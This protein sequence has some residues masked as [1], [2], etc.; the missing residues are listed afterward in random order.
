MSARMPELLSLLALAA[1][2]GCA[3]HGVLGGA[4]ER[5]DEDGAAILG[6]SLDL[7]RDHVVGVGDERGAFCSGVLVSRRVVLT[8]AHCIPPGAGPRGGIT[9]VHVGADLRPEAARP[10]IVIEAVAAVPHPGFDEETYSSDLAV[11]ELA[12][13]APVAPAPLLR[14]T[15]DDGPRYVGP[16]FAFVGHGIDEAGVLLVRRVVTFPIDAVGPADDA[17]LDTGSGPVDATQLYYRPG[18]DG[19]TCL[20]DSGGPAFLVRGGVERVAG[21]SSY[22]DAHCE[23]DGVDARTDLPAIA[24]FIQPEIDRIE[25]DDPC[26]AD[27]VC[28]ASCDGGSPLLDPDCAEAHCG[29]DGICA[30][31]CVE[32]VDPDCAGVDRCGP[33]GACDPGCPDVD[34]DC[35][36][37]PDGEPGASAPG[38][39]A[40]ACATR[41]PGSD[42]AAARSLCGAIILAALVALSRRQSISALV[43]RALQL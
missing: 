35:L 27:G 18:A 7:A 30:A 41:V 42:G 13:P 32:P 15:M 40:A 1:L 14:E 21:V 36:A 29:P 37:P 11:V 28:G 4:P 31:A 10:P 5:I 23:I 26:R 12:A 17:G 3:S 43:G 38:R 34:A 19:N 16:R 2:S 25:G 6:G 9:R 22:G 24:A 33:D 8:A 20:G 39:E